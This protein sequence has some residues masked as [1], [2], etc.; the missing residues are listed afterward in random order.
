MKYIGFLTILLLLTC[1]SKGQQLTIQVTDL[2]G[3]PL[4]EV[5][6]YIP[7]LRKGVL[8]NTDGKVSIRLEVGEYSL[9]CTYP[10]YKGVKYI[11]SV[12]CMDMIY[13]DIKLE[14]DSLYSPDSYIS[15][16]ILANQIIKNCIEVVPKHHSATQWYK[17]NFYLKGESELSEV[18]PVIDKVSQ[19]IDSFYLSELK[20]KTSLQEMYGS[21]EYFYPDDYIMKKEGIR[22]N[23]PEELAEKGV[24]NMLKGSIY[25]GHFSGF[26]S[27]LSN[28]SLHFYKFLYEGY[29]IVGNGKR[30]KIQVQS[31]FKDPEL[32]NGHLYIDDST[33]TVSYAKLQSSAYNMD[34]IISISY[35]WISDNI[36]LPVTYHSDID[37]EFIGVKGKAGYH[38]SIQYE[39][40][41]DKPRIM[42]DIEDRDAEKDNSVY[43]R[44]EAFWHKREL[45]PLYKDSINSIDDIRRFDK[46][47]LN[48]SKHWLGKI[49]IGDY[50]I[51][52]KSSGFSLKYNGVKMIFRDY[53]YV[54][55]FWLGNKFDLK[56]KF[57]N[58]TDIEANTYIYYITARKSILA[59]SDIAY[60][61][62]SKRKGQLTFNLGTRSEDFNNLSVTRYQN[63]FASLF[64]GENY[65]FFYQ[66]DYL[67]INNTIHLN[68]KIRMSSSLGTERRHGLSNHTDFNVF[69][70]NHIKPNIFP[71]DRFD[72]T[73]YSVGLSYSPNSNYS[74]TEALDMHEK[75]ITPVFNIEYQEAFS[76]W[77]KNNSTYKKIK[78]GISHNIPL[79]YFNHVDY[80]VESGVF[81]EKGNKMHF[82]DYQHF[83]AS[84]LL[85]NLNSLF[86]SFLLL[87]N[88]EL[89]TNRYWINIFL[90][91]SGKYFL[92]KRIPFLQGKPFTENLHLKTLFTPDTDSYIETGYS[93]S[94]NRYFGIGIFSSFHNTKAKKIGVRFSLN[95]RS[96]KYI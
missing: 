39:T 75:K 66:K 2:S 32:L 49:I 7:E 73:Y 83:G 45:Y 37:G 21:L 33:W 62:N 55:G 91:Y 16:D 25:S 79:D 61:Y 56:A 51:G 18:H 14:K 85:L 1:S 38:V 22:G 59:G 67:A 19:K 23:M 78:G 11:V 53:N 69:G 80:K 81:L 24:L 30:Y 57:T 54:D 84:D 34:N 3:I 9:F 42:L 48:P 43:E 31:K 58:K 50:I 70:R 44:D 63:Y 95:L 82:V 92:L 88:Y 12:S 74:I 5:P 28:N 96:L 27:P 29:Y 4:N 89:Q 87:D 71:N 86:D 64:F 94:F 76:S 65:N 35:S 40:I 20:G 72:R 68:R 13:K 15:N 93:I 90:N 52:N 17:A 41:L 60:N 6:V 36:Y 47:K 8:S 46:E 10:G 77:Q 26:I